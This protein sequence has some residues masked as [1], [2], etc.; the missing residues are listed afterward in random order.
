[1]HGQLKRNWSASK[2]L[3]FL[4]PSSPW[5][6]LYL[7]LELED[8]FEIVRELNVPIIEVNIIRE[9]RFVVGSN[10]IY[11]SRIYYRKLNL[12]KIL[13]SILFER[14]NLYIYTI[15]GRI[16]LFY[17][18][19]YILL[20][21]FLLKTNETIQ[22][23]SHLSFSPFSDRSI[24]T[25]RGTGFRPAAEGRI[26]SRIREDETVGGEQGES[27]RGW[28]RVSLGKGREGRRMFWVQF[29]L[30]RGKGLG[31][32][33]SWRWKERGKGSGC[34]RAS[35]AAGHANCQPLVGTL[36]ITKLRNDSSP[37]NPP[38]H[39][40]AKQLGTPQRWLK[41]PRTLCRSRWRLRYVTIQSSQLTKHMR[42]YRFG[43]TFSLT[44]SLSSFEMHFVEFFS[45]FLD[46]DIFKKRWVFCY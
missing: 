8:I 17:K 30:H 45:V 13:A 22:I 11:R 39:G 12:S 42:D 40:L 31:E 26:Q 16:C 43:L 3:A 36:C 28:T 34:G 7:P 21:Y 15:L 18:Y 29:N 6:I 38:F 27:I 44:L 2:K 5:P 35:L 37:G 46:R 14:K 19:Y 41:I 20:L 33:G 25:N 4:P 23:I 32:E 24:L 9:Y 10:I 1:M